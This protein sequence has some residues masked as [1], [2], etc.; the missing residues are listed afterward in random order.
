MVAVPAAIA[1]IQ[2]VG[3]YC[4]ATAVL[5]LDQLTIFVGGICGGNG[6]C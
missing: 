1:V 4:F 3:V 5:L 2:T 6:G